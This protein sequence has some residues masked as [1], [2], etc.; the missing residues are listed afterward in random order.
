VTP[1]PFFT[2]LYS[3]G[4]V[5]YGIPASRLRGVRHHA[6]RGSTRPRADPTRR[7]R[8]PSASRT[9]AFTVELGA[10]ISQALYVNSFFDAGNVY[11][12]ARQY[13]PLRLYRSFGIGGRG[14]LSPRPPRCGPGLRLDRV[15]LLGQPDPSWKLH[16][17]LGNFF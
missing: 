6:R 5:Q 2:E 10:R 7:A 13:N 12:N 8:T 11:R 3:M 15:N 9:Q 1:G 4:G 16:F 14:H 17:R